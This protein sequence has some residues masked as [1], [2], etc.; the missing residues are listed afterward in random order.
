MTIF[1]LKS[2]LLSAM[3]SLTLCSSCKMSGSLP[4]ITKPYLGEYECQQALFNGKDYLEEF[5][6]VRLTLEED[7]V[8]LLSVKKSGNEKHEEKGRYEYNK[9]KEEII[10]SLDEQGSYQR[11][12]PLKDGVITLSLSFGG[13][14]F[15]AQFEQK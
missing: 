3:L 7:G 2:A 15:F 5:E 11:R 14:T 12:F 4:D 13:K 6:Y 9:E 8:C 10:L 1:K